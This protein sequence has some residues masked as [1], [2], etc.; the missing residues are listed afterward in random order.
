VRGRITDHSDD[1]LAN[2]DGADYDEVMLRGSVARNPSLGAGP[3]RVR[4]H[5]RAAWPLSAVHNEEGNRC[6]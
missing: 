3:I 1:H 4:S 6:R 2:L 5:S